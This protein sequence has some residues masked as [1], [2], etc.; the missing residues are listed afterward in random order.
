MIG[1]FMGPPASGKGTVTDVLK[2]EG[3][4]V[5]ATGN[6][7]RQEAQTNPEFKKLSEEYQAKGLLVPDEYIFQILLKVI[8]SLPEGT[9]VMFDG[10]PRTPNQADALVK[11]LA[12]ANK[13]IDAVFLLEVDEEILFERIEGRRFCPKCQR[14][15]NVNGKFAPKVS[16]I[17]DSC[18]TELKQRMDDNRETFSKRLEVY[19]GETAPTVKHLENMGVPVYKFKNNNGEALSEIRKI[20]SES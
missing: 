1:V 7:L 20:I 4:T 6:I 18:G 15:Y 8:S 9:S 10:V 3:I 19:F 5:L 12:E 11:Y 16:G 17:C 14:T 2:A 13:K